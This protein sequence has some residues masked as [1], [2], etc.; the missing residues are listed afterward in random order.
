[1]YNISHRLHF[2]EFGDFAIGH[3]SELNV[4]AVTVASMWSFTSKG[5]ASSR[6]VG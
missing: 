6:M 2:T 4:P 1:M 5:I 3:P